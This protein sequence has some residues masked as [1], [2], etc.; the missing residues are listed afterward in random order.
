[1][2]PHGQM[3]FPREVYQS[4]V[5]KLADGMERLGLDAVLL[6]SE[7]NLRYFSGMMSIV[8]DS[9][10]S[11][12]GSLLINKQGDMTIVSALSNLTTVE[13]T[14]CLTQAEMIGFSRVPRDGC[15]VGFA[16]GLMSGLEKIGAT[17]GTLGMEFGF[18]QRLHLTWQELQGFL[19]QSAALQKVDA[20]SIIWACR[21]IKE[22]AEV[23]C[24]R[25]ANH[26]NERAIRTAFE[27]I[28]AG[29]STEGDVYRKIA[30]ESFLQGADKC[31]TLGVR[32]GPGRYNYYNCP[33]SD[34]VVIGRGNG[35]ILMVDGGPSYQGYYSDIIRQ[36]VTGEPSS[37]QKDVF[38]VAVAS[39][40]EGLK[41]FVPGR[42]ISEAAK[43]VQ[44][45]LD[46]S[47]YAH[48]QRGRGGYG[49]GIG[50]D[51]HEFPMVSV[52][53]DA[54]FE[55]GM[56]LAIEPELCDPEAGVFGIEQN[57]VITADGYELLS[58][59]DAGLFTVPL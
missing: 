9:K 24:L 21:S 37:Y 26:I 45:F 54:L 1:M 5:R 4:R 58:D 20:T 33:P 53:E 23:E 50:L 35:E 22:P 49:H 52:S 57:V 30:A 13:L 46:K 44:A 8:W 51:V 7:Q 3:E 10:A 16:A 47:P 59:G 39:L 42:P 29:T 28:V 36:A 19:E 40:Y 11:T 31:L 55:E 25:K 18:G 56:V 17:A 15:P 41:Y 48:L 43:A 34:H 38:D 27:A 6:T 32:N 12:P 2:K 14:S